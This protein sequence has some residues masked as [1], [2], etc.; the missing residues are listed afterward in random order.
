MSTETNKL[1]VRRYYEEVLTRRNPELVGELFSPD[2]VLHY[3]DAPADLPSGLEGVKQF[4]MDFMSGYSGMHF[5]VDE[6]TVEGDKVVTHVTAHSSAPVGPVM[7]VPADP[8]E[9]ANLGTIKG[10]S[11]DRVVNGKI[12]ESWLQ[13]DKP[14]PLPQTEEFP[15]EGKQK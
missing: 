7:T 12:V 6:Q 14:N 3:A 5:R 4:V 1:L 10:M 13:F 15:E 11:T 8:E 2:Y 9:V